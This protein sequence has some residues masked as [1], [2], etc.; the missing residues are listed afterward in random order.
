MSAQTLSGFG[1]APVSL[2]SALSDCSHD[3]D[4]P[5]S[6]VPWL[7][8]MG[9]GRGAW[10]RPGRGPVIGTTGADGYRHNP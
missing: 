6:T 8:W 5:N 3:S 9:A 10:K 7:R 4:E 1:R 2:V